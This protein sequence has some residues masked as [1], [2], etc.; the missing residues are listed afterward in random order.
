MYEVNSLWEVI[1]DGEWYYEG[2]YE[3]AES[4]ANSFWSDPDFYGSCTFISEE[5]FY[6]LEV[7]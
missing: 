1:I 6:G 2:P 4:V 5:E 7:R 3:S